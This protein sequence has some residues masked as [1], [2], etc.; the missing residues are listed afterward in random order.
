MD[1]KQE[2]NVRH[3]CLSQ[4]LGCFAFIVISGLVGFLIVFYML[5][6]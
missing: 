3:N 2:V 6:H 5:G 1:E 4:F